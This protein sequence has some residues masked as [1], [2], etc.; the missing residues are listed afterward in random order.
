M[1][2]SI[3]KKPKLKIHGNIEKLTKGSR[4]GRGETNSKAISVIH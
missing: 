1:K 4:S 3:Y 2:R